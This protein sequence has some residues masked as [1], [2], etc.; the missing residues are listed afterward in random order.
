MLGC[1]V[2]SEMSA[3]KNALPMMLI[4]ASLSWIQKQFHVENLMGE[5]FPKKCN[6][7]IAYYLCVAPWRV[8]VASIAAVGGVFA[9]CIWRLTQHGVQGVL[10]HKVSAGPVRGG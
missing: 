2:V 10:V 4:M 6:I 9:S 3:K 5:I 7:T 8:D 1:D